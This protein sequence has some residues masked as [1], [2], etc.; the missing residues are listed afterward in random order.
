MI[1]WGSFAVMNWFVGSLQLFW[2]LF[3]GK[4]VFELWD[5][6]SFFLAAHVYFIELLFHMNWLFLNFSCRLLVFWIVLCPWVWPS[7]VF[8]AYATCALNFLLLFVDYSSSLFFCF[9]FFSIP[10]ALFLRPVS[11]VSFLG[12]TAVVGEG[13][14]LRVRCFRWIGCKFLQSRIYFGNRRVLVCSFAVGH[15]QLG[16]NVVE[17]GLLEWGV[18]MLGGLQAR[19]GLTDIIEIHQ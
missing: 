11:T 13:L 8:P 19:G 12:R 3:V 16:F 1:G 18:E 2:F 14:I 15:F 4:V 10:S 7:F 17:G 9:K 6:G 5:K